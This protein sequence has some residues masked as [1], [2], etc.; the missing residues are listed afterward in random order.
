MTT[1]ALVL[2]LGAQ[3]SQPKPLTRAEILSLV[4]AWEFGESTQHL[5]QQRGIAFLTTDEDVRIFGRASGEK[6]NPAALQK[7][8]RGA[9]VMSSTEEEVS[10]EAA[11]LQH[12]TR[13]GEL[14]NS[15]NPQ[16]PEAE[17]ECRAA[18]SLAPRDP[19]VLLAVGA[20]LSNQQKRTEAVAVY[21]QA[22]A[23]DPSLALGHLLLFDAL[24]GAGPEYRDEGLVEG[25]AAVRLDPNGTEMFVFFGFLFGD[26]GVSARDIATLR[27]EANTHTNDP[28]P[29]LVLGLA[30]NASR[31][32]KSAF[33][34][35]ET[36]RKLGLDNAFLRRLYDQP[37]H[38]ARE[39]QFAGKVHMI[40]KDKSTIA[41]TRANR[42]GQVVYNSD[43]KW[44]YG[45]QESNKPSSLDELKENWFISCKGMFDS[46]KLFAS[47]CHF[48]ES[49]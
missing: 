4:A 46:G 33:A 47:T 43:T 37:V 32:T 29:H 11:L 24:T 39:G 8:L 13:C 26:G 22:L 2:V 38:Q 23:L 25:M 1:W 44:I 30:L 17:V 3:S 36:A 9:N 45:T 12:L 35:F 10:P 49:N 20:S 19:F 15:S 34:E 18:L 16:S 27:S 48:R 31:D 42:E 28:V 21:R 40:D 7:T 5:I 41:I 6:S 14:N